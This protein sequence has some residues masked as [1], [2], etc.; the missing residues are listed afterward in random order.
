VLT[1][2]APA[3]ET[4]AAPAPSTSRCLHCDPPMTPASLLG[5]RP[6]LMIG[7]AALLVL[8]AFGAWA[9]DAWLLLIWDAP[10]QR[11][12]EASRT[13]TATEV[14]R[15]IS[16]LGSTAA[17]LVL[18]TLMAAVSWR[19]CRA[20]AIVALVAT[21]SRPL[22]EFVIKAIVSRDRPDLERLVDGTGHSFPSGHVMAAVALWGLLPL[23]VTL[24]T[25]NR[26]VW[27]GSVLVSAGLIL[28]IGASRVY[29]GV[30]WFSDVVGG[31]I[32]GA[33]FLLW[34][35]RLLTRWHR[36]RPCA[37]VSRTEPLVEHIPG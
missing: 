33:F 34:V 7:L 26:Y 29:L 14:F 35:E 16:F 28:G 8:L 3:D 30:H 25:R 4:L 1:T 10:I 21:L 13:S 11:A 27:W 2:V 18:G 9:N 23:V 6:V 20:V 24:Y 15:A 5:R 36:R 31:L 17:V 37:R 12:V 19:R 22:L 32:V